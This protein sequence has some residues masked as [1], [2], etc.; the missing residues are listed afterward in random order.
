MVNA[1]GGLYSCTN[2]MINFAKNI[3]K[4]LGYQLFKKTYGF[5]EP[6]T[7]S[8]GGFIYGGNANFKVEYTNEFKIKNILIEFNTWVDHDY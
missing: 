7:F 1:G 3:P 8:H 4:V 6:N 5:Y 2:D